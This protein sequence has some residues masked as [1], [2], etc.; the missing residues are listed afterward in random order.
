MR[1]NVLQSI[2]A[3]LGQIPGTGGSLKS[4]VSMARCAK[5]NVPK[6]KLR[7]HSRNL[8]LRR[9]MIL[10]EVGMSQVKWCLAT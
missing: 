1:E 6:V 4:K 10:G 3:H 7:R 2:E 5:G 9:W 8:A